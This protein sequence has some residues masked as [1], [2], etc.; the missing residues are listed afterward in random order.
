MESLAGKVALVTG[1][2]KGIGRAV[3]L[4]LAQEGVHVGLLARSEEQLQAVAAEINALGA[5]LPL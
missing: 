2:G 3:A 4:A 5:K 1:A